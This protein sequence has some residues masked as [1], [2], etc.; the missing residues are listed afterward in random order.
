MSKKT[1]RQKHA[2]RRQSVSISSQSSEQNI[3]RR[4]NNLRN[5]KQ[6]HRK[7]SSTESE[8]STSESS[9]RSIEKRKYSHGKRKLRRR[10]KDLSENEGSKSQ[11]EA[12]TTTISQPDNEGYGNRVSAN[13]VETI[14]K[15][16]IEVEDL[17]V[18]D[19]QSDVPYTVN[20]YL[21][22]S[23]LGRNSYRIY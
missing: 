11:S 20:D 8:S 5:R 21:R 7:K 19:E 13:R 22:Y 18:S 15:P 6:R 9:E 10:K 16:D 3:D 2:K 23:T 1:I 4:R 17:N 14:P 12:S